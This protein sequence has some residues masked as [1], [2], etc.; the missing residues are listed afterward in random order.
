MCPNLFTPVS[1]RETVIPNRLMMAP[2]CQYA[3]EHGDGIA[4]DWHLVHLGSRAVGG[5]GI[6]MSE[7]TAV[8]PR[9]RISP[10]DLG[11]WSDAHAEA[12]APVTAFIQAYGARPAI[13]LAH[14]GRKGSTRPPA[15]GHGPM[16]PLE[17]GW[18]VIA[19][20]S[21]PWP[22]DDPAPPTNAMSETDIEH[23]IDA[24]RQAA[25]RARHA[26][27]EIVE[28]H[29]AHGYLLHEF[30]SPLTNHREDDYGGTFENR[31]R[32][33]REIATAVREVWGPDRPV[34]VRLS[35]TDWISDRESWTIEQTAKLA[36]HLASDGIDLVDISS[37]GI[38]PASSPDWVGPGYQLHLAEFVKTHTDSDI[39]VGAVGGIT[40]PELADEI[41]RNGRADVSIIGREFLRN[42]YFGVEAARALGHEDAVEPAVQY[43]RAY[44]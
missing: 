39:R 10:N 40:T 3:V 8:E 43:R 36:D 25:I 23:V 31:T 22:Y 28:I 37:G 19:P 14:A 24:F 9:G 41:I 5:A 13:Q 38:V 27:F 33:V 15:D 34:F 29:A 35:G 11:I 26:G 16:Q 2:M 42:P 30:L 6:V 18:E 20:S 32:I 44:Q 4:T 21:D 7:A 12:L 1:L 17:G